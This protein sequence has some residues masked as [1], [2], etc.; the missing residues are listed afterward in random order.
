MKSHLALHRN[1]RLI[2]L[3]IL[4]ALVLA[5]TGAWPK[6]LAGGE[7]WRPVDPS[8]LALKAP[9][10]DPDADA[11]AIFWDIRIDDGGENDLVLSH[12][13]RIKI[14]TERGREKES[15]IDIPYFSGTKIKDVAARTIK[16]DGSIVELP[17]DDVV[18]KTI[19]KIS[20][21]KLRTKSFAFPAIEPGAIIEYKWKE[22]IS[23]A[24]ANNL[25]LQFQREIPV[26]S[27]TYHIKPSGSSVSFDVR[28]FNMPR[29][30]FQK[31]KNG[32]QSTTV[33]KMPAFR[34][35]PLMPPEDSVRSWA[36]I[37]YHSFLTL[38]LGY[39]TMASQL[40]FGL[41]PFLKVDDE[42]KRKSAEIIAGAT[43]P[44]EKLEKIFAFCRAN[45]KNTNDKSSGFTAEEIEKLKENKK[46]ADTLKRGVG[47]GIDINL[48]FAALANAAGFEARV[49]LLPDRGKR[50]FDR[51]VV[52]PGAL[53]PANIAVRFGATWRFFDPGF[54]Y[55][56]SD[57]LRWQEEGVD[58]LIADQPPTWVMTP[59]SP[60]EKSRETRVAT[61]RL[62]ENGTLE[63]D[64]SIEYKGH[65]AVERKA[66][67]D[68][69]S[70]TQ[71]EENLKEAVKNRLST[72]E[73]TNIV[74]ENVTDPAKPFVY[75]YHVRVPEY[76]QRTGKRLFLQPAFFQKGI[77]AL[78]ASSTRRYPV[79]FHFPWSEEDKVT[80]SLP[81]G[82]VLDHADAPGPI[83]AGKICRYA[84]KMQLRKDEPVA[85]IY[86]RSFFFGGQDILL[87]PT[88]TYGQL[89]RL[90]DEIN[91]SDNHTIA[92]KQSGSAN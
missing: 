9:I 44:E 45:I 80:I 84:V 51:N 39:Q 54:H 76:A 90:F 14:F 48:L 57:M 18:E 24:S 65:L 12:Y 29:F 6:A 58:A 49:A 1:S 69:D 31:E 23:D 15:K 87:F 53:R 55:L 19:V 47:P 41:Q 64:V 68:D 33:T 67:N 70:P 77:G 72:A 43:T 75:K 91:K 8:D 37:K 22:V 79:Y 13:I 26:Q 82:Y 27:V 32:F 85:L 61:L 20:G 36:M 62:D 46:P 7:E 63:G 50:F 89:K 71:R 74:M 25:R 30:E 52:I 78:F 92:L 73:L 17:K 5:A 10:V 35:E 11:E 21:L 86:N 83:A 28:P 38:L 4:V 42:V 16:P 2:L 81:K 56:T 3:P 40:Y 66:L 59:I 34:E 88:E 60:P